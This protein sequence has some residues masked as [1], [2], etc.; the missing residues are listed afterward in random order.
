VS[1]A[2][3]PSGSQQAAP[4]TARKLIFVATILLGVVPAT[5]SLLAN[6]LYYVRGL[7]EI[8]EGGAVVVVWGE[9]LMLCV[10]AAAGVAG[11]VSL[12]F[13]AR[14]RVGGRVVVGLLLGVAAMSYAIAL[15]LTPIWLGSPIAVASAH[16]AGYFVRQRAQQKGLA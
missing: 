5:L 13:A 1:E 8:P 16:V 9:V 4:R 11:Y 15:G 12:F 3:V 7:A 14:G 2:E 10:V 6:A